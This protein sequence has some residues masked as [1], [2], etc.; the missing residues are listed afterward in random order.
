MK[1]LFMLNDGPHGSE[2][3]Y[4]GLRLAGAVARQEGS[5]E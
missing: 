3:T 4:N 2:M 1:T 5:E